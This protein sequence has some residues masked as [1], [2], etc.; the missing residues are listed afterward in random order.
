MNKKRVLIIDDEKGF[1]AMLS[2]NLESLG[3]YEI[4]VEND[5]RQA[6]STALQ[7][8]PDLILLDIIMPHLEGPDI[9]NQLKEN[10]ALRNVPVIFLTA[11]VTDDEVTAQQGHIGGHAFVAKPSRLSVLLESMERTFLALS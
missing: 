6:V 4:R 3:S 11:T 5:A 1:T 2:L 8:R 9:A 10:P 7:F